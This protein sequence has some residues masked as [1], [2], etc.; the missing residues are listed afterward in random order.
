MRLRFKSMLTFI[1]LMI[2]ACVATGIGYIFYVEVIGDESVVVVDGNITINYL[3]GNEFS[4]NDDGILEFTI[5]NNSSE[6]VNYYIQIT[7]VKGNIADV[8]YELKSSTN[9]TN[10]TN[11]LK[12]EIIGNSFVIEGNKTDNYEISFISDNVENYSGKII[13]GTKANED[14]N[15]ANTIMQNNVINETMLSTLGESSTVNEG[16]IKSTDSLGD[17]YYFRGVV[18]NNY[19]SFANFTWRIVKINGD[20]SVKLILDGLVDVLN[21]YYENNAYNF[22]ESV[23]NTALQN[24]YTTNLINYADYIAN[25]KYCNDLVHDETKNVY[26][27][28]NRIAKN[29]IPTFVCLGAE[30]NSKIGLLTADEV[31]LAGG[32][33]EANESFYL[34]NKDITSEYFTMTSAKAENGN[35]NVFTVGVN[36]SLG[37]STAGNLLRGVR[38]VINIISNAKVV[39]T[40]ISSDPYIL[41]VE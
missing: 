23:I 6:S 7:E 38:P 3:N 21:R 14:G 10:I 5:T 24:W 1:F 29:K 2:V 30:F 27:A 22:D 9:D 28:F 26:E 8:K 13:I 37:Y 17:A 34:Y 16:L 41:V 19:V 40:G 25:Y 4:L 36:G 11:D 35:Y 33:L 31:M 32:S 12:P 15:F 20:G 18:D 39:G